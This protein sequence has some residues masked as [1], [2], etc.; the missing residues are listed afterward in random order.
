M[1]RRLLGL[2]VLVAT[3][4]TALGASQP[5]GFEGI[6]FG[7]SRADVRA[8]VMA[9]LKIQPVQAFDSVELRGDGDLRLVDHDDGIVLQRYRLNGRPVDVILFFNANGRF[10]R[11]E[12]D[13]QPR[14]VSYFQSATKEDAIFFSKALQK[15]YGSPTFQMNPKPVEMRPGSVGYFWRWTKQRDTVYTAIVAGEEDFGAIAVISDDVLM[16]EEP[17]PRAAEPAE[18]E[19]VSTSTESLPATDTG[20]FVAPAVST[21]AVPTEPAAPPADAPA[22]S[23]VP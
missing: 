6:P 12:Y 3:A 15:V 7:T 13:A 9:K 18:P 1:T 16:R 2:A 20:T 22:P 11:V 19:E 23:P 10:F 4:A 8:A 17:R 14:P 5:G 21:S